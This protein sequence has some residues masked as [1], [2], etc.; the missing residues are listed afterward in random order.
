MIRKIFREEI[1]PEVS[2]GVVKIKE[3]D[4]FSNEEVEFRYN[5]HYKIGTTDDM[6]VPVLVIRNEELFYQKLEEYVEAMI[7][8]YPKSHYITKH[9]YIKKIL[10][11]AFN[12]ATY[13][14]FFHPEIYLQQRIDFLHQKEFVEQLSRESYLSSLNT[15]VVS[16]IQKQNMVLET[17]Y[18]YETT[19]VTDRCQYRL[20]DISFGISG[21]TCYIYG[22]QD[23]KQEITK[24]VQELQN[25]IKREL[26]NTTSTSTDEYSSYYRKKLRNVTPSFI[27]QLSI[28]LNQI[29]SMGIDDIKA[30]PFLPIRYYAKEK[31]NKVIARAKATSEEE[32]YQLLKHLQ[33]RQLQIQNNVTNKFLRT[34]ERIEYMT[35]LVQITLQ[36]FELDDM[37]HIKLHPM[38]RCDNLLLQ[39]VLLPMESLMKATEN[40]SDKRK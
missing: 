31:A 29:E 26:K 11:L 7:E 30:V 5:I 16:H 25:R 9:E 20:P 18:T 17:P 15:T 23:K 22:I 37:M 1:L 40:T 13:G 34:F 8:L 33:E 2:T 6:N 4:E 24:D 27:L 3:T 38:T 39:E 35:D 19:L 12:N 28:F 10:A 36:P 21:S 32:Y 14:D